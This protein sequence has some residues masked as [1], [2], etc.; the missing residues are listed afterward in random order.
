MAPSRPETAKQKIPRMQKLSE[1]TDQIFVSEIGIT[2]YRLNDKSPC[3]QCG[4][5]SVCR[6]D[7]AINRYN[8]L[9]PVVFES[10]TVESEEESDE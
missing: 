10:P 8:Y 7:P 6:F 2:P 9:K 3:A 4:Y 1:L 5:R